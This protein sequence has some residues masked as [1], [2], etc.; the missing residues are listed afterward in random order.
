M[1]PRPA[2]EGKAT[3]YGRDGRDEIEWRTDRL[4][5]APWQALGPDRSARL[6]ELT[7]PLLGA[8]FESG[9]LPAQS[10]LGIATVPAPRPRPSRPADNW[11]DRTG[12]SS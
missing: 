2:A 12:L 11:S 8:A 3:G 10:T 1:T 7:G 4:A 6:A 9:L 5:D